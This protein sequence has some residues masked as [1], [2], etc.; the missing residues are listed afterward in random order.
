MMPVMGATPPDKPEIGHTGTADGRIANKTGAKSDIVFPANRVSTKETLIEGAVTVDMAD[1]MVHIDETIDHERRTK[2][3]DTVRA[4]KGVMAVA[5]HD[6]KPHVMIIEY[7]PN[8]VTSKELL[9]VV[10]NEGVRAELVG[11]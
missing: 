5:H 2:I 9:Q 10:R 7:N 1:V 3:A 8:A 4:H 6:E 11:L